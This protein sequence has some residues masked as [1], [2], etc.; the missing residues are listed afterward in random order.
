[1]PA[2]PAGA[3][4]SPSK[5]VN[6]ETTEAKTAIAVIDVGGTKIAGAVAVYDPATPGA[7]ELCCRRTVPTEAQRGGDAVLATILELVDGLMGDA[8]LPVAAVGVGTAGRVDARTGNIAYA[9]EIM[10]GWTGQPLGDAL[11][12][13]T[14]LPTAILNDVQAHAL[15][16]ARWGAGQGAQTCVVAAAG[17]GLGG[18]IVTHGRIVRGAH[19]FAGELGA[20]M[21][22]LGADR[23]AGD[24]C[25]EGVAAGSGIEACYRAAGGE[26]VSGAEIS[27][28]ANAGEELARRIIDQAGYA[29]GLSLADLA[30]LLDPELAIVSGSVTKAGALWR[31]ALQRGFEQRVAPVLRDLPIVDAQLGGDAPLIG[32]AEHARDMLADL[33]G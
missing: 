26:A 27:A 32:A 33:A 28:R 23:A 16:E 22:P 12:E 30:G 31:D 8:P 25:L 10:P 9:N 1:M 29:L 19:G 24:D 17:T 2:V 14:G 11:R 7:P 18:A 13:R 15:G 4:A 6:V 21:N 3:K 5:D 20:T